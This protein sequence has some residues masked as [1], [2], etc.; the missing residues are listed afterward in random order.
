MYILKGLMS[1]QIINT[2][3]EET[4]INPVAIEIDGDVYDVHPKVLELIQSLSSQ[5]KEVIECKFPETFND[6]EKN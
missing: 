4:G 2:V 5:V 1:N 3:P 6:K